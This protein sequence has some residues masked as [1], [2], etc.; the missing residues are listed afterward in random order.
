MPPTFAPEA[1]LALGDLY[2]RLGRFDEAMALVYAASRESLLLGADVSADRGD[3]AAMARYAE[4][5]LARDPLDFEAAAILAEVR[6][7][8]GDLPAAVRESAAV[9]AQ[10]P[11]ERRA[12]QVHAVTHAEM[13][14]ENLARESFEKILASV[15]EDWIQ[16][17]NLGKL[18]LASGNAG[19]AAELFERA[20]DLNSRN[21]E[22]Y[23]GLLE[24]SQKIGDPIRLKRAEA[25]VSFL[26]R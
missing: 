2:R 4:L 10:R 14:N 8:E 3:T 11:T 25:M 18:E 15:P 12:L 13:G 19:K 26:S 9:L 7:R 22:G 23:R 6:L 17:N 20:V 16:L 21:L 24:A 5:L 1:A